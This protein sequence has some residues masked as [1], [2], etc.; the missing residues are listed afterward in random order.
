MGR[1]HTV[2]FAF[3]VLLE[4]MTE[5]GGKRTSAETNASVH[6]ILR[7]DKRP[8]VVPPTK[9]HSKMPIVISGALA[10]YFL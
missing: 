1:L 9:G 4:R 10:I 2:R 5:I 3:S 7:E 6:F 8:F